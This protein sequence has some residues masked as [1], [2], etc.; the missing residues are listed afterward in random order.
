MLSSP[1]ACAGGQMETNRTVVGP[2]PTVVAERVAAELTRLGF[3]RI[4]QGQRND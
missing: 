1:E 2:I 3:A 4:S